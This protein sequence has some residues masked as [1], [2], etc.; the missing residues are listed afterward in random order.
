M[1][2][3]EYRYP[4][5]LLDF[6]LSRTCFYLRLFLSDKQRKCDTVSQNDSISHFFCFYCLL[7]N[8]IWRKRGIK[9]K[10][11]HD[12]GILQL[13]STLYPAI[14]PNRRRM[15]EFG[16]PNS[17]AAPERSPA[18]LDGTKLVRTRTCTNSTHI[19]FFIKVLRSAMNPWIHWFISD[20]LPRSPRLPR[21]SRNRRRW[22]WRFVRRIWRHWR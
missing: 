17:G 16:K 13:H 7:R 5:G 20:R 1:V 10:P 21:V 14:S 18:D 9:T 11:P 4:G 6:Y 12:S 3:V 19:P 8:T 2:V 22:L 15:T